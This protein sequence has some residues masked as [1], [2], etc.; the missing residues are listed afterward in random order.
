[1]K[2]LNKILEITFIISSLIFLN[3]TI[4]GVIEKPEDHVYITT[5]FIILGTMLNSLLLTIITYKP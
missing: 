2:K 4:Y 5:Y 3:M 1:M